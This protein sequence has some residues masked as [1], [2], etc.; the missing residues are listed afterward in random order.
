MR[1]LLA[2][3]WNRGR[4]GAEAYLTWLRAG[5]EAAGDEVRLLVSS[6][7]SAGDGA[8]EYVAY[9]TERPSLQAF[10]QI[11]NPLAVACVR[12]ALREFRP[13]IAALNMFV[14]HLSPAILPAFGDVPIVLLVS[15]Y[16]LLCPVGTK[17]LPSGSLCDRR[18]G[19]VCLRAG[20][21]GTLHWLRDRP[22][23]ALVRSAL[24]HVSR[25][26]TCSEW[27]RDALA[28][29]GIA[30]EAIHLPVPQ[31]SPAYRRAP[32]AQPTFL[33]CGRLDAEKG[34]PL[35]LRAFAQVRAPGAGARLRVVGRGPLLDDLERLA[36]ELGVADAVSFTGWLEPAA[37]EAELARAWALVV[38]SLWAEPLGLVALE[39]IV[40][41]VPVVASRSG[42]L[43]EIV[44]DAASGLLFDNGDQAALAEHLAAIAARRSFPSHAIARE[45]VEETARR[46][47][48]AAHV[49]RLHEVFRAAI[50]RPTGTTEV[51]T[52]A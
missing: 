26:V 6:A 13:D 31:A 25:V 46:H 12:R 39:A 19:L 35:L 34:V 23:Y 15:D 49:E 24:R 33:F 18:A 27:L 52:E 14:H 3:D 10:L 29:E 16:K 43:S 4:G 32:T 5:L 2:T 44:K 21:T 42:G 48:I 20:C 40:R 11:V 41:S 1:I 30:S 51:G 45:V 37:V 22:R 28:G 17:L 8:A 9:G 36:L 47:S 38:P 50:T 7:G